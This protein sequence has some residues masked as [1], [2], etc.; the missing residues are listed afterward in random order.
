MDVRFLPNPFWIPELREL[1]GRD[2][3]VRDY[4]LAQ[5]DALSFLDQYAAIL[6]IDRRR[7][8]PRE[9]A[10]PHPRRGVHRRQAPLRRDVR[11]TRRAAARGRASAR[12]SSIATSAVSERDRSARAVALGGGHGLHAS[13]SALRLLT[14][15]LTAIVTVADD[16]GSSGRIRRELNVLP[17]GDLRMALAALAGDDADHQRWADVFQHRLGGSGVL[18]GHPVGNIVLTGL[19]DQDGADAD[20][21]A[22]ADGLDCSASSG[23]SSR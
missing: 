11:A 4:V 1:T 18:A 17:P 21:R 2:E 7:L 12:P 8:P 5:Q 13:L 16:G 23:A 10:L 3:E 20:R 14:S 6:N 22:G 15:D 19:L 9:Q